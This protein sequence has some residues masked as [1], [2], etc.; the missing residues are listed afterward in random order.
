MSKE[1]TPEPVDEGSQETASTPQETTGNETMAAQPVPQGSDPTTSSPVETSEIDETTSAQAYAAGLPTQMGAQPANEEHTE[2]VDETTSAL[3][4][5]AERPI[6]VAEE[7]ASEELTEANAGPMPSRWRARPGL[8]SLIAA[9]V[10]V[11]LVV[12]LTT[13][14]VIGSDSKQTA[15]E[16]T[17]G[18]VFLEPAALSG[19]NP[20]S[21]NSFAPPQ[22]SFPPDPGPV[23]GA[24]PQANTTAGAVQSIDGS[25]PGVFAGTMNQTTCDAEGLINYL[26][27]NPDRAR[28][29]ASVFRI[30]TDQIPAFIRELTPVLLRADTRVTNHHYEN[31]RVVPKQAVLE[32]GTAVL[33]NKFG[34]PTVR[35]YSGNPLQ[36]PVA[37]RVAPVYVGPANYVPPQ[38]GTGAAPLALAR[39]QAWAGFRPENIIVIRRALLIIDVFRLFDLLTRGWFWRFPGIVILD[40]LFAQGVIPVRPIFALP[41]RQV[42]VVVPQRPLPVQAEPAQPAPPQ[43]APPPQIASAPALPVAPPPLAPPPVIAAGPA[44]QAPVP[45]ASNGPILGSS[46][47]LFNT[48]AG[49]G[50]MIAPMGPAGPAMVPGNSGHTGTAPG[51]APGTANTGTAPGLAPGTANTGTAP[52][53]V[54]GT[55]N[56]G[57]A[58]GLVPGTANTGTAPGTAGTGTTPGTGDTGTGPGS[59]EVPAP[60]DGT[61]ADCPP[62]PASCSGSLP[63]AG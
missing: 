59:A 35:C 9:G 60:V 5:S 8:W 34:E 25:E 1:Q 32:A 44:P 62:L 20:F 13:V 4:Y 56:T 46:P 7:P 10:A 61:P 15:A 45:P 31:S 49:T 23:P 29:W 16:Q 33:V 26:D 28:A 12:T 30:S 55:A 6:E 19:D 52:G 63:G 47:G 21:P 2:A 41:A 27:G 43:V 50:Q 54:P 53:L 22:P 17:Q 39:G 40:Q 58:P 11:V 18:E 36:A 3:A 37:Q 42:P 57:T 48:P 24:A 51:L 38:G 14:W